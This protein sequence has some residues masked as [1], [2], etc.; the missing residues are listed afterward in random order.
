MLAKIFSYDQALYEQCFAY[1]KRADDY[2]KLTLDLAKDKQM[3]AQTIQDL[4]KEIA[5]LRVELT[6]QTNDAR[7]RERELTASVAPSTHIIQTD[8]GHR[9]RDINPAKHLTARTRTRTTRGLILSVRNSI[10]MR[11][12]IPTNDNELDT[13]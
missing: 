9:P 2:K 4:E 8:S 3:N 12:C 13:L 5:H 6:Q 11:P 10:R 1:Q 7:R